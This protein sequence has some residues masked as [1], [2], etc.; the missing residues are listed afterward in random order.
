M[1]T[2]LFNHEQFTPGVARQALEK[3]GWVYDKPNKKDYC[4]RHAILARSDALLVSGP[5]VSSN[6]NRVYSF[7]EE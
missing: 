1:P 6:I 7:G 4:P 2:P 3:Q 5:T